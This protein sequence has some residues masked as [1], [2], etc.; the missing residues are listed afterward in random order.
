VNE[1]KTFRAIMLSSTFTDLKEHRARA[2][3]AIQKLGYMARVMEHSGAQAEADVI[4]TSLTM[5]RDAIAYVAVLS[6]KYGQTP[7]DTV[8]NPNHL[9]I[10]ELEFNE[11][12]RLNRPILLFIMGD[13]HLVK[14]A[15][16]ETDSEKIKKLDGFRERAKQ[17]PNDGVVHRIYEVFDSAEQFST[18]AATALGNLVRYLER[19]TPGEERAPDQATSSHVSNIPISVPF[20]FL[21]R[22]DDLAAIDHA[23]NGK[24]GRAAITALHGLRGVGKTTLAAAY[25][26]RS[27]A[28]YRIVWWI[29]AETEA[30]IRADLVGLGVQLGWIAGDLAEERAVA[31]VMD[32]L[33][34]D[35]EPILLVF[36]N[37]IAPK[38]LTKFLPRGKG[39]RVIVTSNAPNWGHMAA[40][41][42]IEVWSKA[43][44]AEFLKAR[45]GRTT[46]YDAALALSEALEGLPL[47]HEQ[48]AAYCE[49]VGVTL[50]EYEVRFKDAP[51]EFMDNLQDA[52]QAYHDGRTVAKTFSLA[53]DEAVR[54]HPAAE[55][56]ITY[57]SLLAS[58][59]IPL[60]LFAEGV[61]QFDRVIGTDRDLEGAIVALRT[62]ALIEREPI[63]DERDTSVTTDCIRVHR[64]VRQVA[65]ARKPKGDLVDARG[66]LLRGMAAIY[67]LDVLNDSRTWP[68]ARRLD[69]IAIA[70]VSN[71]ELSFAG[72]EES[73]ADLLDRLAQFRQGSLAAYSQARSLF[74]LALSTRE[75]A[76]GKEHASTARSWNSL[77]DLSEAEGDSP[78]ALQNYERA[79]SIRK[80]VL[81]AD[82]P[83]LAESYNNVGY[84]LQI[85]DDFAG[86]QLHY[87]EALRIREKVLGANH[88]DTA[89]SYNNLGFLARS[90][91]QFA[92]ARTY[93]E[94]AL[95]IK[96]NTL[97]PEHLS[98]ALS[99]NN[100]GYLLQLQGDINGARSRYRSA[101]LIYRKALGLDH[102]DTAKVLDNLGMVLRSEGKPAR[103]LVMCTRALSVL[104]KTLGPT[105]PATTAAA[106]HTVR[107]L[108][109]MDRTDEADR[110]SA[111]Y[112]LAETWWSWAEA[113]IFRGV[114]QKRELERTS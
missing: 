99:L 38:E 1:P 74:R 28:S 110:T 57:G 44:G 33:H 34:S 18:A 98:T 35:G 13:D 72:V 75:R 107:L 2:I 48:A 29:R 85:K 73:G 6:H 100:L 21:G 31:A 69:A 47:A 40:T 4:D 50:A 95:E 92:R 7:I 45:S 88:P 60:Y 111:R 66:R 114:G 108:R 3:Q 93:Y 97:G 9:S 55:A 58:E 36:D 11:A 61:G 81:D 43:V 65:L 49:R 20:H 106:R 101:L 52:S 105:H 96:Q 78:G 37:A 51:A 30:T 79:L 103:A 19:P 23:L 82:A 64:L 89:L 24:D 113:V 84:Q 15:D 5:V 68:R 87:Q 26:E 83:E 59:P 54:N 22:N 90:Q 14:K 63:A 109:Q 94:R 8:R 42:E 71:G 77:G 86:A 27:S 70:L 25:A 91:R 76:L 10:T 46:E 67:P 41:I 62:L 17:M 39:R 16:V 80:K 32:R 12:K 112:G 104:D 102:P 56:L 53:I